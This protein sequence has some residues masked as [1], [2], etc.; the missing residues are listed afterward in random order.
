M[1]NK[2]INILIVHYNTP[3]LT[4]CLVKSINKY[5]GANCCI[6][7]FDNSDKNPFTYKQD[8][9][10]IFDNTKGQ[11]IDF[12]KWLSGYKKKPTISA[13]DKGRRISARHCFTVDK[14]FDLIND[15]FI[16][17]DSDVLLTSDISEL[18]DE[19]CVF[20]GQLETN[21]LGI[22]RLLPYCCFI[23]VK[24]CKSIGVRYYDEN[25]MH[26]ISVGHGNAYDTGASFYYHLKNKKYKL[27]N[28]NNYIIHYKGA[29]WDPNYVNNIKYHQNLTPEDWLHKNI[30]YYLNEKNKR[31]VYTCITGKYDNLIT[32]LYKQNDVDYVC[33]TD[34]LN[35]NGGIWELREI[36]SELLAL[37]KIKQQRIIKIC[38]HRYLSE[39]EDSIWVDGSMDILSDVNTFINTYCNDTNKQVFMRKHPNRGC[40]Y[41]EANVCIS[42]RKDTKERINTQINRY[43]QEGFPTNYGLVESNLI[44]RKHNTEYCKQLMETWANEIKNGSHRDQLSFNYALWKCGDSGFKYI[45][46]DVLKGK[47]FKWYKLHN[48]KPSTKKIVSSTQ[49]TKS[50]VSVPT[51]PQIA[52]SENKDTNDFV[53][54]SSMHD[55]T[56][57]RTVKPPVK[58]KHIIKKTK[59]YLY[60]RLNW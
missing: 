49:I 56:V 26:G 18:F 38:P 54:I 2:K 42:M 46:L 37:D 30:K 28:L 24:S 5:V 52:S 6:Y 51:H 55:T 45:D 27:V 1:N 3:K 10:T 23:N 48:W 39:Y 21:N 19:N 25:K 20:V 17:L 9:I 15:S 43:K 8:N 50:S 40:I 35:Q 60:S 41:R 13:A 4:E 57:K 31:V 33:F 14:C 36:P 12:E 7:I 58:P 16:L 22:D 59:V 11:I 47:Y 44:Y 34:N 53:K 32:P 29:S